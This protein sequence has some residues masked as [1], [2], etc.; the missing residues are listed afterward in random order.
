[1]LIKQ[2]SFGG[3]FIIAAI[4]GKNGKKRSNAMIDINIS[5]LFEESGIGKHGPYYNV[6]F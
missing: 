1:L 5:K 3:K 4:K 6:L 2:R